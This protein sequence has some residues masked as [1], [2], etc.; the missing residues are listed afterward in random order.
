M[1]MKEESQG[2]VYRCSSGGRVLPKWLWR[3]A[4]HNAST[5]GGVC[6]CKPGGTGAAPSRCSFETEETRI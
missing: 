3:H 5:Q 2:G 4:C 6:G 1:A